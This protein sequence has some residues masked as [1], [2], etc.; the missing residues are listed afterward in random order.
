MRSDARFDATMTLLTINDPQAHSLSVRAK[1]LDHLLTRE[2]R[3]REAHIRAPRSA[4]DDQA[5]SALF[6]KSPDH[7]SGTA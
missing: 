6:A 1:A 2:V 4:A 3:V 7:L 5:A